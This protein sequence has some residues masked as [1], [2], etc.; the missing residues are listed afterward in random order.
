MKLSTDLQQISKQ[1][2]ASTQE[3]AWGLAWQVVRIIEQLIP[4]K[5]EPEAAIQNP[6]N[7]QRSFRTDYTATGYHIVVTDVIFDEP[8]EAFYRLAVSIAIRVD[9]MPQLSLREVRQLI[10]RI[11]QFLRQH[12]LEIRQKNVTQTPY[13]EIAISVSLSAEEDLLPGIMRQILPN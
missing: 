5:L 2:V 3:G 1:L 11:E 4:F 10:D 13:P 9:A 12:G 6:K 8:N 7:L